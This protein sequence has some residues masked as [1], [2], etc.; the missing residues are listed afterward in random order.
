MVRRLIRNPE[1]KARY[2]S[3]AEFY[4]HYLAE[5]TD[6][7]NRALHVVGTGTVIAL[8]TRAVAARKP[9]L[10]LGALIAG[11]GLAWVGHLLFE[12]NKPATFRQPLYSLASDFLMFR[13]VLLGRL[14][15][16]RKAPCLPRR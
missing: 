8:T 15:R 14:D 4:P 3:L 6:P 13:D 9:R 11:Y 16:A 7:I 12:R 1:P 10:L 5:H 2:P